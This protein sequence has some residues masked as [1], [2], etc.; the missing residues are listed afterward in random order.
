MT[1]YYAFFLNGRII[2]GMRCG[3]TW[4]SV[5]SPL[6]GENGNNGVLGLLRALQLINSPFPVC[7][8]CRECAR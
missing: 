6:S 2:V 4:L 3:F 8:E 1:D 7:C 5:C